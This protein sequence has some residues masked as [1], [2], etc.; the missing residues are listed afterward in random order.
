MSRQ[1][2]LEW[3]IGNDIDTN[4]EE[5]LAMI[6]LH[7]FTGY[8]SQTDQQLRDEIRARDHMGEV[9]PLEEDEA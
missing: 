4:D 5:W 8:I 2:M 6:L 7:G 9:I 1:E 3:L